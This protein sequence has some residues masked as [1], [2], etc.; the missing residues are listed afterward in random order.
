MEGKD[1]QK[2]ELDPNPFKIPVEDFE[3]DM[4][5]E[6][7]KGKKGEILDLFTNHNN[8]KST[9]EFVSGFIIIMNTLQT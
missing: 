3:E 4:D 9:K 5:T 2:L 1:T 8:L 7:S 6:L